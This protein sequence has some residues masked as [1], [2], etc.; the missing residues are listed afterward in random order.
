MAV[1]GNN[2]LLLQN[3]Y[4]YLGT[5]VVHH[6]RSRGIAVEFSTFP[7]HYRIRH[8]RVIL[9]PINTVMLLYSVPLLR[10]VSFTLKRVKLFVAL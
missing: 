5:S 8:C 10:C 6:Y 1:Q 7:C 4:C 9:S 3:R 2:A